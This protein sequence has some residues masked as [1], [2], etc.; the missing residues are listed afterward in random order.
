MAHPNNLNLPESETWDYVIADGG[1]AGVIAAGELALNAHAVLIVEPRTALGR[2]GTRSRCPVGSLLTQPGRGAFLRRV[3]Q[4][5]K[6][7][8]RRPEDLGNPFL[9][10]I[11]LEKAFLEAG[12]KILYGATPF[13]VTTTDAGSVSEIEVATKSGKISCAASRDILMT[14]IRP[15]SERTVVHGILIIGAKNPLE[16]R[17]EFSF[18]GRTLSYRAPAADPSGRTQ[19]WLSWEVPDFDLWEVEKVLGQSVVSLIR[20]IRSRHDTLKDV[21]IVYFWDEPLGFVDGGYAVEFRWARNS[22]SVLPGPADGTRVPPLNQIEDLVPRLG[23]LGS[24]LVPHPGRSDLPSKE[25]VPGREM[26]G[27]TPR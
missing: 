2:E 8:A 25:P 16:L 26:S 21:E 7:M 4:T 6:A 27:R 13:A 10:E 9:L 20:D 14:A 3:E 24:T 12:G 11:A 23:L 18:R 22:E 17:G 5:A 1:L 15:G 19:I